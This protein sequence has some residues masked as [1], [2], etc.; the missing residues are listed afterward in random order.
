MDPMICRHSDIVKIFI[1]SSPR[2]IVPERVLVHSLLSRVSRPVQIDVI[3][4]IGNEIRRFSAE[5]AMFSLPLPPRWKDHMYVG[6][7]GFHYARFAPPQLCRYEGRAIY[8]EADQLLLADI[9][10]LW[11]FPLGSSCCAAVPAGCIRGKVHSNQYGGYAS[12]VL[13]Y[14]CSRCRQL[15]ALQICEES[16]LPGKEWQVFSMSEQFLRRKGLSVEPLPEQWNDHEHCFPNTK[17]LH[18]THQNDWP[19]TKPM[20]PSSMIWISEYLHACDAGLL[21]A[22]TLDQALEMS[23]IS[24]RVRMLARLPSWVALGIDPIWEIVE[25]LSGWMVGR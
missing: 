2:H 9:G 16:P 12:S 20:H 7:T 21:D 25:Y 10:E 13:L 14:D 22:E 18:F 3:D 23:T 1:G 15:D 8:L 11:D 19:I 4:V 17:L 5:G 24:Q 6:G